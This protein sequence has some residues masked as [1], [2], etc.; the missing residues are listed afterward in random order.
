MRLSQLL[1]ESLRTAPTQES[2]ERALLARAGHLRGKGTWLPLGQRVRRK[3]GGL[4]VRALERQ[5][6]QEFSSPLPEGSGR[7]WRQ[8]GEELGSALASHRQLP[9]TLY[10]LGHDAQSGARG[11]YSFAFRADASSASA[12][13]EAIS[14]AFTGVAAQLGLQLQ[15]AG[16]GGARKAFAI[17]R[18]GGGLD[19]LS[20]SGCQELSLLEA[21]RF[22]R[23]VNAQEAPLPLEE[24]STPGADTIEKLADYLNVPASRTAKAVFLKASG[25][26][27]PGLIVA[28]VRGDMQLSEL[29]LKEAVGASALEPAS[30]EEVRAA[31]IEPGYGSPVGVSRDCVTVVVDEAVANGYNLVAGANR[32]G[33]HLLNTN[34]G[35]DYEADLVSDVALAAA[36]DT[37]AQCG[38]QLELEQ[39]ALL[40]SSELLTEADARRFGLTHLG[41]DNREHATLATTA[42]L[43]LDALLLSLVH[44]TKDEAWL[45]WPAAVAPFGVVI[46]VLGKEGTQSDVAGSRLH[47]ELATAGIEALLDDRSVRAG[48]KF[49]DAD[50]IG[51]PLRVTVG[52]RGLA[53]G[54][55]EAKWRSGEAFELPLVGAADAIKELLE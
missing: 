37:C 47:A 2:P 23:D 53:A 25:D 12:A 22:R 55:L 36:G 10:T 39:A 44:A 46:V 5:G 41:A 54:K 30:E 28:V 32:P 45:A 35:R 15:V 49:N 18:D 48:V 29:K 34:F 42:Q 13:A 40:G 16:A 51:V 20:C 4:L 1:F 17:L 11:L 52:E 19:L 24:V 31:G 27:P 8:L 26:G 38:G 9:R 50:L 6:A 7:L 21:A 3:L 33:W 14:G 43:D